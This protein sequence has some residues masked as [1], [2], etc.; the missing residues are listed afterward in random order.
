MERLTHKR[1]S[2][3]GAG[4][5]SPSK[6][7]ELVDRLAQYEDAVVS[8][9]EFVKYLADV[10]DM[11]KGWKKDGLSYISRRCQLLSTIVSIEDDSL[12]LT[13]G[14]LKQLLDLV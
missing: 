11:A 8:E 9:P 1:V 14:Q 10:K 7:Q 4:Y 5:W 12:M 6:K 2:G 13:V 3:M